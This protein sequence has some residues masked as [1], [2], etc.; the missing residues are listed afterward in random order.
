[1]LF[2]VLFIEGGVSRIGQL[3]ENIILIDF[4]D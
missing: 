4:A 1:L 2:G 3:A